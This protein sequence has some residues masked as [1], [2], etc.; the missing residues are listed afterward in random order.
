MNVIRSLRN[1][2]AAF[3]LAAAA[4]PASAAVTTQLGFLVDGSGSIG[5]ANFGL[6]RTAYAAALNALP[7]DGTVEV[8]LYRFQGNGADAIIAPTIVTAGSLAGLVASVNAMA[9]LG[10]GTPT[11][12]GITAISGAMLGSANY[13]T[14]LRSIINLGTDGVPNNQATAIAAALAA[15]NGGIDAMTAEAIGSFDSGAIRDMVF[16]PLLGPCN[17]CGTVLLAGSVPP[18]PMT[19]NPWVLPVATFQQFEAALLAKV[20]ASTGQVPEPGSMA[21]LALSLMGMFAVRRRQA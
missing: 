1:T 18:D 19:S 3:A 16:S 2:A 8:T 17:N 10:G 15:R 12:E 20:R 6:M 13:S 21:L 11:T 5:S 4:L 9:F 14:G 7:T